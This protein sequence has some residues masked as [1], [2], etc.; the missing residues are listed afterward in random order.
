ME[1]AWFFKTYFEDGM[2]CSFNYGGEP[3]AADFGPLTRV[4]EEDGADYEMWTRTLRRSDGERTE[5][6]VSGPQIFNAKLKI[7]KYAYTVEWWLEM[8]GEGIF[9]SK[10]VDRLKY[11]DLTLTPETVFYG[12]DWRLPRFQWSHGSLA[13]EDDFQPVLQNFVPEARHTLTC[14]GGRASSGCLPYF[15][16]QLD[17]D[18]GVIFAVGWNGQW[19]ADLE[20][21][22][23]EHR[24]VHVTAEMDDA[25]FR[26]RP[27]ETLVLPKM[28]ALPW[29]G[30]MEDSFNAFRR[31]IRWSV[32][33]R[34]DGKPLTGCIGLRGWGGLSP[35]IH[36]SK[37]DEVKKHG[38][39]AE[40]YQI[41]AGWN[42]DETTPK[43]EHYYFDLWAQT[44]GIW[45]PLPAVFPDG[46][47]AFG[48]RCREAGMDLAVWFEPE[49]MPSWNR[50]VGEHPEY[51]IGPRL[52]NAAQ[53]FMLWDEKFY[54]MVNLGYEPARRWITDEISAVIA[55]SGMKVF[56]IDFNYE[57]LP[58]WKYNDAPDRRGVT[59]I[60]YVN[61][62]YAMLDELLRRHPGLQIDNC[63]SG[64]RRLDYR[65][66]RR[67]VPMF[68]RSDYFCGRDNE[69]D[70]KQAHTYG[71]SLWIPAHADSLGS[72]IGHTKECMDTYRVRS[73]LC[74]GIGMTAPWWE[75]TEEEAAWYRK[76]LDDAR[77]VR[78][79]MG[80][81]FYPLTGYT[82]SR[83]DW[84]AF[85]L[86]RPEDGSGMVMA[87]RREENATPAM[88]F[89]LRG[90]DAEAR[91]RLRDID[92]GDLGETGGAELSALT[93]E[94]P[95][96]RS[97][98]IL[99]YEKI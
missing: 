89:G 94:I 64:G 6:L 7:R 73:S 35:E 53:G 4:P 49:R 26:V 78:E 70:P 15:N 91:Y 87:F 51:F 38:L 31:F 58:F 47:G 86:H 10:I 8:S 16:L 68:C 17:E 36:Q 90:I 66:F 29:G 18:S 97:A 56:R 61:G 99:F 20:R 39:K 13:Q 59:E 14:G 74:S 3:A 34:C 5:K 72:C 43:S 83:M 95:E 69:P 57:P 25:C 9:D 54:L 67:S 50:I 1:F 93:V 48:D 71:L 2:P 82:L 11:A 79:Y 88:T 33:P 40:I 98:R 60:L 19:R 12:S 42:G 75:I 44:V 96:P 22:P 65:M 55:E 28:A 63:A 76:M 32:L 80:D 30:K 45:K 27:G 46:I 37:F 84:M 21:L 77:A 23:G 24:P 62:V 41:D 85:Q 81:D 52:P 92:R